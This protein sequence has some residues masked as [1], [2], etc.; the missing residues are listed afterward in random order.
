MEVIYRNIDSLDWVTVLIFLSLFLLTLGKYLF[1][2]M[3]SNFIILPF[4]N[5]YI[6]QHNKK[7]KLLNWF[8]LLLTLFQLI[9]FS[10]FIFLASNV[11]WS[12]T[13]NTYP[14][15]FVIILGILLIYLLVKIGLQLA[16]GFVFNSNEL[17]SEII[18]NKISYFN[19]SSFVAFIANVIL[20]YISIESKAVVYVSFSCIL[21]I[22]GIGMVNALRNHQKLISINLFYFILYLCAL[23]IAPLVIIG[24]YLND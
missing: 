10:L 19:Y 7:G 17:V 13:T 2:G 23:E 22:N 12:K 11:L 14:V 6:S 1:K 24:S 5:K 21:F 16:N 8:H 15:A 20:T 4:N 18:F 9:N 3:F